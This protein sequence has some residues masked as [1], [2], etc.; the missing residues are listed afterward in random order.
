MHIMQALSDA[1]NKLKWANGSHANLESLPGPQNTTTP[2][3]SYLECSDFFRTATISCIERF[4]LCCTLT[5]S[6]KFKASVKEDFDEKKR[7]CEAIHFVTAQNLFQ[8]Q[9]QH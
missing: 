7:T 8:Q 2:H 6:D 1:S 4:T 9:F 5:R 3:N